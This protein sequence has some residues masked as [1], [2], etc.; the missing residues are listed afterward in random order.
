MQELPEAR[1]DEQRVVDADADPD[2]RDEQRRDRVDVG[3]P[4][5]DEE[6][7]ERG[8]DRDEREDD[9]HR[10]RDER[11]EDDQEHQEGC[12]QAEQLLRALLDRRELG[13]AVELDRHAGRLHRLPN[14][15]LH[16]EDSL[17]VLVEDDPVELRL[18]VGDAAVVRERVLVEGV[19]DAL[20][21]RFVLGRLEL[22]RLQLGDR[23][24]DRLLACGRV[25]PLAR[26]RG[27]DEV[28]H[29]AL[30]GRE[31]GLDQ[32]GRLLRVG[33]RDLELVL[34]AAADRGDEQDQAGD[35]PDP[36]QDD[37]P[38]VGGAPA[39]PAREPAGRETLVSRAPVRLSLGFVLCH[40][41]LS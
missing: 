34:E 10:R 20:Q 32:V 30:L 1:D 40:R 7:Q 36:G 33:A 26:R 31:L 39:V 5:E 8:H 16:G 25:Q 28:Q 15:V 18:G 17:A 41:S 35:D 22:L 27:E 21:P 4:G 13:I 6:E 29:A 2:H 19:A 14:G 24:L 9:R 23:V 37:P 38:R 12:E 3:Q 11:A